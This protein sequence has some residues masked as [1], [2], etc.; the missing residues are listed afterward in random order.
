M[1]TVWF[2]IVSVMVAIYVVLDG[3]DFGAGVLHL[4]VAKNDDER[5][6]VLAAVGPFWDGNEV[7]LLAGGG[8]LV[9]AFPRVYA[10]GFS[11]FYLPLMMVLW[12]LML[13]ALSIEF[14][15]LEAS[16]LWRGFWDTTFFVSSALMAIVLGAALGNVVRGVPLN[17]DG[18]FSGPLFTDFQLGPHPGVLDW[19][20]VSVGVFALAVLTM[21]GALFLR[22]KLEG[23]VR[24]RCER[25]SGKLWLA[26]MFTGVLAT[27]ETQAV[28][29]DLFQSVLH[30]PLALVLSGLF[31]ICLASI[32]VLLK[33]GS[34]ATPFLASA[35]FIASMLAAT[36]AGVF[37]VMLHSTLG[38]AT[39]LTATN[40]ASGQLSL[41]VGL[42]WWLIAI[43]LTI[44]YF[45]HLFRTFGGKVKLNE[46][47]H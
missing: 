8:A 5:R 45:V 9:F 1:E 28:R 23:D 11:G 47:A 25:A 15:S 39:D 36:A 13:R 30:R 18:Y 42:V 24:I 6:S 46:A 22:T 21:H 3:F 41:H 12:L 14:R 32:P 16:P 20:T 7:W 31:I 33:K 2:A 26:V 37:P 34:E 43:V 19:Y 4:F 17:S 40:A 38:E 35:V 10:A 29:P 27:V 44:L